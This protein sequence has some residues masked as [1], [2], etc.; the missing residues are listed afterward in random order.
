MAKIQLKLAAQGKKTKTPKLMDV[1]LLLQQLAID[2]QN[3]LANRFDALSDLS[4]ESD[5]EHEWK[6]LLRS[7]LRIREDRRLPNLDKYRNA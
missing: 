7:L 1:E 3:N 6:N 4:S 5:V 2:Y